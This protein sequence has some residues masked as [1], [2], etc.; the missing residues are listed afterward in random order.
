MRRSRFSGQTFRTVLVNS[1]SETVF[2]DCELINGGGITVDCDYNGSADCH[3]T[4]T[5]CYWGTD[6]EEQIAEWVVDSTDHPERCCTV[7]FIPFQ[8]ETPVEARSWSAVKGLFERVED[9]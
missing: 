3:V 5:N 9:E 4:M 6:S 2:L 8:T 1:N 7:D